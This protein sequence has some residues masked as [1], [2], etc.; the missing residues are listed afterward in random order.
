MTKPIIRAIHQLACGALIIFGSQV[1]QA[2]APAATA[3]VV[4]KHYVDAIHAQ[5]MQ[6]IRALIAED[7]QRSDYVKCTAEMDNLTCLTT[8]IEDTIVKPGAKISI[9]SSKVDGD[10]LTATV[11]IRSPL[12]QQVA[13]AERIV[14]IEKIQVKN[15]KIYDLHF[16]PDFKDQATARFFSRIGV[17]SKSTP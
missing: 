14:G 5:D 6:S 7:V 15:G 9:L 4:F 17:A 10:L 16:I 13:A 2:K 8:Y 12:Y 11:E 1:V 3:D